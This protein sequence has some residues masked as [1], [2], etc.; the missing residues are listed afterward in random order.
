VDNDYIKFGDLGLPV[1]N[2]HTSLHPVDWKYPGHS[3]PEA[4]GQRMLV[5]T[6]LLW[7]AIENGQPG[8]KTEHGVTTRSVKS[9][10]ELL[11]PGEF[12]AIDDKSNSGNKAMV[13]SF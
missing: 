12:V 8:D 7:G 13:G 6:A 11:A 5:D 10:F 9:I 2:W 4:I 3:A 1:A